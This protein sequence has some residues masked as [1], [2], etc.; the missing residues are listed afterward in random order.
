[1]AKAKH[2]KSE[3]TKAARKFWYN[4][5]PGP[6]KVRN[7][8]ITRAQIQAHGGPAI[9]LDGCHICQESEWISRITQSNRYHK[10]ECP[11]S[12]R[13]RWLC[14]RQGDDRW[15]YLHQNFWFS[16]GCNPKL[17][18]PKCTYIVEDCV[19]QWHIDQ[20]GNHISLNRRRGFAQAFQHNVVTISH[21]PN[22]EWQ[23]YDLM[24]IVNRKRPQFF[25]R[26]PG[27]PMIMW[28][29][30]LWHHN[31]QDVINHYK[32][33]M[34]L[35]SYPQ[36]WQRHFS[37]PKRTEVVPYF[38]GASNF[39]TRPNLDKDNKTWDLLVIGEKR[40]SI[41]APRRELDAQLEGLGGNFVVEFA[42]RPKRRPTRNF[43][44]LSTRKNRYLNY[45]SAYLGQARFV[46][47]G[48]CGFK[49]T[50]DARRQV[51]SGKDMMLPKFYECLGSGAIP[52]MPHVP[53]LDLLQL[54]PYE[55]YIPLSDVWGNNAALL[56][57]LGHYDDLHHIAQ[58][59]VAWHR[60]NMDRLLFDHFEDAVRKVTGFKYPRR[61]Y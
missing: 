32:P 4:N 36:S 46:I 38:V 26:P 25:S 42:T 14:A 54:K 49:T 6:L 5:Q 8:K 30:D 13:A 60:E 52:I 61:D 58:N 29:H 40:G 23:Y 10:H 53:G 19:Y 35:T 45:Y 55:H 31:A 37:I 27:V 56:G 17:N 12:E 33:E 47:F 28:C 15:S 44:P 18:A 1:M 39:Y 43:E 3:L 34:I 16:F 9:E 2:G 21:V 11:T 50:K 41:Y 24:F 7:A 48:P 51:R 57:M 59:A 20:G 22:M